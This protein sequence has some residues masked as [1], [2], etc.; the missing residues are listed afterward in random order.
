[1]IKNKLV[2]WE[3]TPLA[4]D[5]GLCFTFAQN[6]MLVRIKMPWDDVAA[7]KNLL[8]QIMSERN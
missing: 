4:E 7:L 3:V 2:I 1:M 6:M 5:A 8:N